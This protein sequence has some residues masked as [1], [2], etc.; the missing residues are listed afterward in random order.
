MRGKKPNM[1][2]EIDNI[3]EDAVYDKMVV[4]RALPRI[5]L[6]TSMISTN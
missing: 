3:N 1:V 6:I 2:N 5:Y 4:K